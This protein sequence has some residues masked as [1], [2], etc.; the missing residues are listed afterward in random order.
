MSTSPRR[1][2]TRTPLVSFAIAAH[3]AAATIEQAVA[4]ALWQRNVD[5]EVVVVDDC[6]TDATGALL[7]RIEDPRLVVLHNDARCG[8]A[9]SLNRGL[10]KARA[11]YVARLDADD[12]AHPERIGRQLEVMRRGNVAVLGTGVVEIDDAGRPGQL[13]VSPSGTAG[14]AWRLLFSSPFFHPSTLLDRHV[15][16]EHELRYDPS[17]EQSQDY[18]LWTRLLAVADGDNIPDALVL[19]RIHPGQTSKRLRSGQRSF[20]REIALRQIT[21]LAP[22]L[23]GEA[24]E[25]AWL[26][27]AGQQVAGCAP[28][29]VDAYLALYD[30]FRAARAGDDLTGVRTTVARA[31]TRVSLGAEPGHRTT[32]MRRAF[33]VDPA[34][35]MRGALDRA[36]RRRATRAAQDGARG[37]IADLIDPLSRPVRV[38]VVSPEPTPYRSPLLDRVAQ[39]PEVELTVLYAGRTVAGRTWAVE[40]QHRALFLRGVRVP[41]VRR[42]LR[43]DYPVTPGVFRALAASWPDVVVVSGWSQFASQAAVVWCRRHQIPYLLLVSSH[44]AVSR[45]SWRQ[46]VRGPIVPRIVRGA[47]GAFALGT[48]S[49]DSLV[50]NGASAERIGLFANTVDVPAWTERV[51]HLAG[52]RPELRAALGL[53]GDD[54]AVLCVAR[55]SPEKRLDDLVR[56]VARAGDPRLVVVLAGEGPERRGLEELARSLGVRLVLA[57]EI[58]WARVADVYV[59]ADVF[60]LLSDWEA[61]GV[62]VN[63]AACCGLPLVLSDHV[64]AA[65]DLLVEGQNGALVSARDVGSAAD[66][67][68]RYASSADDRLRAGAASKRI[69]AAWGYEPS[70]ASFVELVRAAAGR[71]GSR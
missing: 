66:A 43:H 60:A 15:L 29:A 26:V 24:A 63:E 20:Q 31:V 55:L 32:L 12:V 50:A 28:E 49:R 53:G 34:L 45:P 35:A 21:T 52:R 58:P 25:L 7:R 39:R 64:G 27:G 69:V 38:T 6:S 61:W 8:L 40:P 10:D 11:R 23:T 1:A 70:V 13:H 57:G 51:D 71:N 37:V 42:L 19:R 68:R 41:G 22:E 4:S 9:V 17:Y 46:V 14:V 5:V 56:A 47:W 18:E 62:V 67:L 44:D 30:R 65:R 54:V 36:R 59:A 3:D 48:L 33:D 2:G 16:D